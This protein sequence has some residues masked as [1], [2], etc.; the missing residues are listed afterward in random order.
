MTKC[1]ANTFGLLFYSEGG[2]NG[3]TLLLLLLLLLLLQLNFHSVAAVLALVQLK[4]IIINIQERNNTKTQYKQ[5]KNN[6][7]KYTY[8]QN[9]HTYY[10]NTPTYTL[11]HITKQDK[12]TTVQDTHQMK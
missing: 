1:S 7:H 12:T 6:K 4:Q 5:Y 2:G 10:Q 9:T 11:T 3:I 8:Y